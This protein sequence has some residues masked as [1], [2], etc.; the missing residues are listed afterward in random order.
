MGAHGKDFDSAEG[1]DAV[2]STGHF[3]QS[4]PI[5]FLVDFVPGPTY[6]I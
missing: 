5:G 6:T 2:V 3:A 4:R 1:R